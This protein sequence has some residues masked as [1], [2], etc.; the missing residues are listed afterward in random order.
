MGLDAIKAATWD[1]HAKAERSGVMA[2]VLAGRTSRFAV[3]LLLRGLLPVYQVLDVSPFGGAPVARA[4]A[5]EGD[6]CVLMPGMDVPLLPE[7]LAYADRVRTAGDTLVAHAYVRYLGDLNGGQVMRRRLAAC[8][9][10]V[11]P[12]L[13]FFDYPGIAD[14]AGLTRDYR[15][16]LDRAVRAGDS[17]AIAQEAVVAFEMN[18]ALSEAVWAASIIPE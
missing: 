14:V 17:R 7:G 1:L 6:L 18:I 3:A 15:A 11:A 2:D 8:L 10:D 9:G 12:Q 13:R 16:A 4:E 5:I